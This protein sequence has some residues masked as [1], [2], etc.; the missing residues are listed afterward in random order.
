MS[1]P[2]YAAQFEG[3]YTW[4]PV[5]F[6]SAINAALAVD[7]R[8]NASVAAFSERVAGVFTNLG[9]GEINCLSVAHGLTTNDFVTIFGSDTLDGVE[10]ITVV[11]V[12]NFKFTAT[13]VADETGEW[14]AYKTVIWEPDDGT[15][16]AE[17]RVRTNGTENDQFDI[18]IYAARG[19]DY[20][21]K[22]GQIR[23]DQGT[24]DWSDGH[25]ADVVS[26]QSDTWTDLSVENVTDEIGRVYFRTKGYDRFLFLSPDMLDDDI[27]TVFIDIARRDLV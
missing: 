8:D 27:T 26:E 6:L 21:T 2:N 13:Y 24:Q 12:D 19:E 23:F 17:M 5:G 3:Q 11:D 9:G 25:F 14:R 16:A 15:P 20:Y 7:E 1:I 22:V 4:I 18:F 10:Q